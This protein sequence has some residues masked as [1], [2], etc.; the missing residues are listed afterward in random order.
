MIREH[1]ISLVGMLRKHRLRYV[2]FGAIAVNYW[3]EPRG[4]R[5][6]DFM[7]GVED[8]DIGGLV[9]DARKAGWVVYTPED[10][11]SNKY[12]VMFADTRMFTELWIPRSSSYDQELLNHRVLRKIFRESSRKFWIASPETVII[13][14]VTHGD[15]KDL[16]DVVGIMNRQ[17][18]NLDRSYLMKWATRNRRIMARYRGR[19]VSPF[20]LAS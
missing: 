6:I 8:G 11:A 1:I 4:T 5:D 14:K 9:T 16:V 20:R 18:Q 3:G 7:V 15:R 13:H 17:G 10:T 2:L 19:G 12:V